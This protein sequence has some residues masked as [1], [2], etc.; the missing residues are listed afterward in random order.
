MKEVVIGIFLILFFVAIIQFIGWII[1]GIMGW[2]NSELKPEIRALEERVKK[3]E[4]AKNDGYGKKL[5][6]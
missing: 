4:A 1:G 5:N 6:D 2:N 3:L